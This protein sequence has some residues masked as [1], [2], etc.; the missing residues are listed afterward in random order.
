[1]IT[2]GLSI[3]ASYKDINKLI[4]SCLDYY[5][6]TLTTSGYDKVPKKI[7]I[8]EL[9]RFL[10]Y[11]TARDIHKILGK[12]NYTDDQIV[13]ILLRH[14]KLIDSTIKKIIKNKKEYH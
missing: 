6:K 11:C 5:Q 8:Q 14:Q 1:M 4:E 12:E 2:K 10:V 7:Y 3:K 9:E 13:D